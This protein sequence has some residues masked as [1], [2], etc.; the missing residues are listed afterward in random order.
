[1]KFRFLGAIDGHVT[2]SCTH[3]SYERKKKQFLVDCGLNQGEG[4]GDAGNSK[5]FPFSPS[6][7]DFVLLTHA[8]QDHCGLLPKLYKE[9]FV[10]RVICT[11]ATA[12]LAV[13]SLNDS[14]RHVKGIYSEQ[15]V[16]RLRFD[17]IDD[18]ADFGFSR[19]LPISDDLFASF[20]R[21]SHILGATSI[22]IGWLSAGNEKSYIVMSGDVG[23]NTK[24]IPYQPLLA[25]QQGI[26]GYPKAIVVESTYGGRI[27]E[28]KFSDFDERISVLKKIIKDEVFD[29][30]SILIIPAF[31][32][33]RTQELLFDIYC[34]FK[35]YF[36]DDG[37]C[38]SPFLSLN[39][40]YDE[41]EDSSWS[42][43][44]QHSLE[45]AIETLPIS[46]RYKWKNSIVEIS[47]AGRGNFALVDGAEIS[48]LDIVELMTERRHSYP[49]DIVLDSPLAKEM[50]GVFREE[51]CRRQRKNPGE[52]IYRNREMAKR[53]GVSGEEAVDA[54]IRSLLPAAES[55]N[56]SIDLGIHKI[57]YE[58]GFRTPRLSQTQERGCIVI[59]GGGMCDG[60]PVVN[61]LSKVA[62]AKREALVLV[63]GYMAKGS[64]GEALLEISKAHEENRVLPPG[65]IIIGE[66]IV[67]PNDVTARVAQIQSYYSGHADQNGLIDFI[68]KVIG[69]DLDWQ[70]SKPAT[71]FLNHGQHSSRK[72]LKEAIEARMVSPMDRDREIC[73]IELPDETGRWYDLDALEWVRL[74]PES[75]T[76][77]LMRELLAEQRKTNMLL[78]RL[79]EQK[80]GNGF[81]KNPKSNV[82]KKI[83]R[84]NK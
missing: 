42:Y 72:V 23:C 60:G 82:A 74:E 9:G 47:E 76:D 61:H 55:E 8:H 59:T 36:L 73:N 69:A 75:K 79:I 21:S 56:I 81:K 45:R 41:F 10:G 14:V 15:D 19:M 32:L 20:S 17:Y 51:L 37:S 11:K 50:S 58:S 5:P 29:K 6:E 18:R 1:M 68:F 54:V 43:I 4:V 65:A 53:L 7:I 63:A 33:Q 13:I 26:F 16:Q 70:V 25:G 3:F 40:W 52:T 34:V 84:D 22:T 80:D 28:Q 12:R 30:K 77:M 57:R 64:L 48:I 83:S 44:T 24:E 46:E 27:R 66:N 38:Q 62:T 78:L 67:S 35:K 71:V 31:S 49:V 2:G 39:P